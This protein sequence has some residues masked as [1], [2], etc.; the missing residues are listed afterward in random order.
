M[1]PA[2]MENTGTNRNLQHPCFSPRPASVVS[3]FFVGL[4]G[5]FPG[6]L[7][8]GQTSVT[9]LQSLE[10]LTGN[11]T[12]MNQLENYVKQY[13]VGAFDI[14][15]YFT[16]R[17]TKNNMYNVFLYLVIE[18]FSSY[19]LVISLA[20]GV[21]MGFL[22]YQLVIKT[23]EATAERKALALAGP[24][25]LTGVTATGGFLGLA[26]E[27]VL[28]LITSV[29]ILTFIS[30]SVSIVVV[31]TV[32]LVF[33]LSFYLNC[34]HKWI[35]FDWKDWMTCFCF[36]LFKFPVILSILC[37][38]IVLKSK[39][40][41]LFSLFSVNFII[42]LNEEHLFQRFFAPLAL[43]LFLTDVFNI[44]KLPIVTTHSDIMKDAV[45]GGLF[46]GALTVQILM[47][48]IGI[49]LF[50]TRRTGGAFKICGTSAAFGGAAIAAL[51]SRVL[52]PGP[53]IGAL[54]G[55]SGAAGVSLG[56]WRALT[57]TFTQE[58]AECYYG[59]LGLA[60]GAVVGTFLLSHS[61]NGLS[62][63][64]MCFCASVITPELDPTQQIISVIKHK[65]GWQLKVCFCFMVFLIWS[66]F[67][68]FYFCFL[69]GG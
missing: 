39:M 2:T 23:C 10:L 20:V 15:A 3:I 43:P 29:E 38:L 69:G 47:I 11:N 46:V 21:F 14:Y 9:L 35:G 44:A 49:F 59:R 55:V 41:L 4:V 33:A 13:H 27:R 64:F 30:I 40:I 63:M 22:T 66:F 31:S 32:L 65:R 25:C 24:V 56:A 62:T 68:C 8:L 37:F 54:V 61:Y 5:G 42:L 1:P 45:L 51:Q 53:T 50:E 34:L 18:E 28:S 57:D 67:T 19:S 48:F 26:L 17:Q 52:G 12:L 7:L 16:G 60:V 36:T 58:A 6:G